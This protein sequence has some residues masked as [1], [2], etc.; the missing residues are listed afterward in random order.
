MSG[1]IFNTTKSIICKPGA[2]SNLGEIVKQEIGLHILIVTD[3]GLIAAGLLEPVTSSLTK[4]GVSYDIYKDVLADPPANVVKEAVEKAKISQIEGVIGLG[5]GSSMDVAKLVSLLIG[6]G[7]N[8]DDIY[9][10]NNTNG[11]RLPLIQIPTTAGTGSEVTPISVITIGE[12]EKTAVIAP[13]LL[14]DIAILDA[15][16]TTGL[17]PH[18]TAATGVDAI[19]HAIE[20]YTSIHANNNPLSKMLARQALQLLGQNIFTAVHDG[21]NREARSNMLLGSMLAGQAFANSSVGAVHALAYP[22]GGIF[23]VP[24]G[25]SNALVLPEVMKFNSDV[26]A[27]DYALLACDLFPELE[28]LTEAERV[29]QFITNISKMNAELGL[30]TRLRQVGISE[31]DLPRLTADGI[32]QQ[33]ILV[34][35]PKQMSEADIFKIYQATY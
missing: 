15:D 25:L 18:V 19:V 31:E 10:I 26:C 12:T 32:K 33:R 16:L 21:N 1:F 13:Q 29:K 28:K 5:G 17:P 4:A 34:N 23:H 9:G 8:L 11:K 30:E 24:H 2:I 20:G 27:K 35:N 14:P 3:A 6:G 7:E 22:I